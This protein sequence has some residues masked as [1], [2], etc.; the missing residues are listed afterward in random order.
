MAAKAAAAKEWEAEGAAAAAAT[1]MGVTTLKSRD[2][3]RFYLTAE[4]R[5]TLISD[6]CFRLPDL[7]LAGAKQR[8][9][10]YSASGR[11]RD[12]RSR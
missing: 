3:G 8:L 2:G 6:N 9:E 1:E 10:L 7:V 5:I 4:G 12:K 11:A